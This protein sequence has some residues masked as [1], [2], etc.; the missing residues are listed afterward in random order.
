MIGETIKMREKINVHHPLDG[1]PAPDVLH[2]AVDDDRVGD[3]HQVPV[4]VRTL[5][6]RKPIS[7]TVPS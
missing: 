1:R 5:V 7:S 2:G 6:E 3:A 4:S